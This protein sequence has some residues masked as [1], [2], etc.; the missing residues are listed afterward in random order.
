MRQIPAPQLEAAKQEEAAEGSCQNILLA[1]L[2]VGMAQTYIHIMM[3]NPGRN[4]S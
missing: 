3:S 2:C 4:K 1:L